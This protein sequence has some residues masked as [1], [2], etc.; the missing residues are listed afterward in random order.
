MHSDNKAMSKIV[1]N[2]NKWNISQN[3]IL[4]Y[5]EFSATLWSMVFDQLPNH[6]QI[7]AFCLASPS[8]KNTPPFLCFLNNLF[9]K[10][11][12][13]HLNIFYD[14]LGNIEFGEILNFFVG[15]CQTHH[16]FWKYLC[17]NWEENCLNSQ[18]DLLYWKAPIY[19]FTP[20]VLP[21]KYL[22]AQFVS[23]RQLL[24]NWLVQW[25]CESALLCTPSIILYIYK[26]LPEISS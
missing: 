23:N 7:S 13:K 24:H 14:S 18:K 21:S 15:I 5:N 19:A 12:I 6:L 20:N 11:W 2:I 4:L 25:Q 1:F 9:D 10:S 8:C 3:K 22:H 16:P 17:R 26:A